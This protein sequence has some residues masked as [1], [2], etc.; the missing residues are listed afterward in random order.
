VSGVLLSLDGAF[1]LAGWQWMF[2]LEGVPSV[3]LGFLVLRFLDDS[4]ADARWLAPDERQALTSR[5]HTE[6]SQPD[7]THSV[8]DALRHPWL[9]VLAGVYFT[10]PVGLYTLGFFLPQILQT[11]FGGSAIQ[12]G[13]L[14]AIPY[15]AGAVGMIFVSRHSDL[16]G[17]RRFHV[18][19]A[20]AVAG[21]ALAATALVDSLI[22]AM[23]LLSI[24]TIGLASIGG[25]FWSFATSFVS[26]AGAAAGIALIN[27]IGN[28]G[29]FVGPYIV[30]YLRD[31]TEDFSAS[32]IAVGMMIVAGAALALMVPAPH[33][34]LADRRDEVRSS[35]P[36]N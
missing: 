31:R 36:I 26:G 33:M 32:L 25:P 9:W 29:G 14:S 13:L 11:R 18:A 19:G 2:L 23:V 28:I 1:G 20:A 4:P 22:P 30:G 3:L 34:R 16:T 15:L 17:E 8:R 10:L 5:L 35:E 24:A 27:S 12:I 21:A 6:A 7:T